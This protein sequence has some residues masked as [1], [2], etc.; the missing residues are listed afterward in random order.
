MYEIIFYHARNNT[1]QVLEFMESLKRKNGKD[2]RINLEKVHDY[3]QQLSISG[4]A[5]GKPICKHLD[6]EI[7]ELRPLSNRILF[8]GL[9][10]EKYILLHQFVKKTQK[11]PKREIE[12]AKRELEDYL[13]RTKE[14]GTL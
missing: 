11:T 7:W 6:G 8:A 2:A 14:N 9:V 5:I 1:S 4:K 10:G 12:K 3:I 13:E